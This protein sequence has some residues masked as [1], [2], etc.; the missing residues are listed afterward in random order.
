MPD[1]EAAA[2][3]LDVRLIQN[4]RSLQIQGEDTHDKR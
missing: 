3:C 4:T 2:F 1:G